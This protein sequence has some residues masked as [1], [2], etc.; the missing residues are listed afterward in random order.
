M[1][2]AFLSL[3]VTGNCFSWKLVKSN[4][5]VFCVAEGKWYR[6]ELMVRWTDSD[7]MSRKV[8]VNKFEED[9]WEDSE[10]GAEYRTSILHQN[11]SNQNQFEENSCMIR[12]WG[13]LL[14]GNDLK[15]QQAKQTGYLFS[16]QLKQDKGS[17]FILGRLKEVPEH[18]NL[19]S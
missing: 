5:E 18:S 13:D 14:L 8:Q 17:L 15:V 10:T 3:T 1:I 9:R 19:W 4:C 2:N 12:Y 6:H 16:I 7:R 11:V